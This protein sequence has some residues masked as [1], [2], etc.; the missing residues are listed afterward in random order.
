MGC[1]QY[2]LRKKVLDNDMSRYTCG[3][4]YFDCLC[5]RAGSCGEQY[6]PHVCLFLEGC[7]CNCIAVSATRIYLMDKYNLR[8]DP[9]D[10]RLIRINNCL[11]L[12]FFKVIIPSRINL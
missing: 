3:Q 7:F 1:T 12:G 8:S 10:Y 2:M 6:C 9:C 5:F 11:Q 4:G